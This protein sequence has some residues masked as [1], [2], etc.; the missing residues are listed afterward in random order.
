MLQDIENASENDQRLFHQLIKA[1]RPT[2]STGFTTDTLKYDGK[3][4]Q[5][6]MEIIA[7]WHCYFKDLC[8][9][10]PDDDTIHASSFDVPQVPANPEIMCTPTITSHE[11]VQAIANLN[12]G[13]ASGP[14]IS[15][16][17]LIHIGKITLHLILLIFNYYL[18]RQHSSKI[19]KKGLILPFHKGKGKD[20]QDPENYRGITLTST[21]AKLLELVLKSSMDKS[22]KAKVLHT[23]R[24]TIWI[25]EK[26]LL[27]HDILHTRTH[28]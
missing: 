15:P 27:H 14:D 25:P 17:H 16:E 8:Q 24:T 12:K 11:L 13:K 6:D 2:N 3:V 1:Q 18:T 22:L 7:G 20:T 9:P 10:L 19:L 28:N 4:F 26:S 23:R 21:F 5:G